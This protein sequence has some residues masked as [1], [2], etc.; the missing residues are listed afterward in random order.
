MP[1][2]DV[3]FAADVAAVIDADSEADVAAMLVLAD[4]HPVHATYSYLPHLSHPA[5]R[6]GDTTLRLQSYLYEHLRLTRSVY[7]EVTV[8]QRAPALRLDETTLRLLP[9]LGE[10]LHPWYSTWQVGTVASVNPFAAAD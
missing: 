7:R 1:V 4:L 9:Y 6:L 10:L 3:E 5:Q 8:P 2:V